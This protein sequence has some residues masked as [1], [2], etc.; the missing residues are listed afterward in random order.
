MADDFDFT[1]IIFFVVI[2]IIIIFAWYWQKQEN[3]RL[4]AR[5]N[6]NEVSANEKEHFMQEMACFHYTESVTWRMTVIGTLIALTLIWLFLRQKMNVNLVTLIS[7]AVIIAGVF[8]VIEM[9]KNFHISRV[10]CMKAAPDS[11][12]FKKVET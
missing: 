1:L 6:A 12:W 4:E 8:T 2:I 10:V 11:P 7:I 5:P 9:F 3:N